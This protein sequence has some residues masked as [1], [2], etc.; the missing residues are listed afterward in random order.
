MESMKA[1]LERM[2]D[3]IAETYVYASGDVGGKNTANEFIP[4]VVELYSRMV[5]IEEILR[6]SL[7]EPERQAFWKAVGMRQ[8]I[9]ALLRGSDE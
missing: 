9:D 6:G 7:H 8:K 5:E 2:R 1:R 3:E 4:L